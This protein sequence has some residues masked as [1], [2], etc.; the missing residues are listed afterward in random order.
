MQA[1]LRNSPAVAS[2]AKL[3]CN[4]IASSTVLEVAD[5]GFTLGF[6]TTGN[7]SFRVLGEDLEIDTP[8][9]VWSD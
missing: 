9:L 8:V 7:V 5:D 6:I 3:S 2:L 1:Y 4:K